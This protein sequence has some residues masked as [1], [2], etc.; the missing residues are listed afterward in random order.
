MTHAYEEDGS[1][2]ALTMIHLY[3]NVVYDFDNT[4]PDFDK[5]TLGFEKCEN[6]K[7]I[8]K[9]L[10]GKFI[11]KNLP[12]HKKLKESKISKSKEYKVGDQIDF[13]SLV[14]VGEKIAVSG[15]T[16]GK[17][18]AGGMKR[19]GFGGLEATH[20]V[21]ISHRSHGST[22]QCQ[23]PGKVFKGKKMAGHMGVN[24]VTTK[25]LEVF[26]LNKDDSVIALKGCIPGHAG[27]DVVLRFKD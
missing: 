14:R 21:S 26:H 15:I 2:V 11:K 4:N 8:K 3:D 22:G 7:N 17:G 20:G 23:D 5:L 6:T 9:P 18:F 13:T 25:N 10:S 12:V 27:N 1:A 16:I 19:W 24:K